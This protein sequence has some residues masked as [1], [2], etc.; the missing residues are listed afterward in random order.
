[1]LLKR[2]PL[3]RTRH[4]PSLARDCSY[5]GVWRELFLLCLSGKFRAYSWLPFGGVEYSLIISVALYGVEGSR[6]P[7]FSW[8]ICQDDYPVWGVLVTWGAWPSNGIEFS[9]IMHSNSDEPYGKIRR[10]GIDYAV[11]S[12]QRCA[13]INFILGLPIRAWM[14]RVLRRNLGQ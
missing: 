3:W 12:R 2:W 8:E 6:V 7:R 9:N 5:E 1:M 13:V 14:K 11:V 10:L 4:V